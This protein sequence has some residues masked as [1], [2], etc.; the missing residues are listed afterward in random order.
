MVD[1][2]PVRYEN[3]P[4]LELLPGSPGHLPFC[5]LSHILTRMEKGSH[6]TE[7]C[8]SSSSM[9]LLC[10]ELKSEGNGLDDDA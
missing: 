8:Q 10:L 7:A 2:V 9:L 3:L 1:S 5:P 6:F 4:F